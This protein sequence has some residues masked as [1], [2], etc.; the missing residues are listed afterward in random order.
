MGYC[1]KPSALKDLQK[2]PKQIQKRILEKLDFYVSSPNP[3]KFDEKLQSKDLGDY[4]YR[5]GDYRIIF[6][7]DDKLKAL[8]ILKVGHR[9]DVCK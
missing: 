7:F 2:L 8:I 1:F 3:L 6:D 5:V 4:R 9:K